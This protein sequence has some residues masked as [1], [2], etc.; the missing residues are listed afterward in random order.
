MAHPFYVNHVCD[1]AIVGI[2][3]GDVNALSV[4]YDQLSR[5][6]YFVAY[7]IVNNHHDAEDVLQQT[8]CE[9]VKN[10][11]RYQKGTN[12]RAWVLGIARNQALLVCRDRK[13]YLPL[14]ELEN[15]ASA[16]R[17]E[18]DAELLS[19]L[20][21]FDALNTL[22]EE[23]KQIVLLRIESGLKCKEIAEL[24]HITVSSA[25]KKYQRALKKLKTYYS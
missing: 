17:A 5:Q 8:L 20:T 25:E 24:L 22:S 9:I 21:M 19:S 23:E 15:D 10:A 6:I 7:A 16:Y 18:K 4:L 2:A 13:A 1:K 3:E 11:H 12:A 14:E